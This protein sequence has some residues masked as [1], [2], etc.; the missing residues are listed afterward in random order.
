MP[1]PAVSLPVLPA[2]RPLRL[3]P[4]DV[5]QFVRMEQC[6]RYLRFRLA[7]RAGQDFM[8]EYGVVPQRLTPLLALSG[9]AFEDGVEADLGG[10]FRTV[11]YAARHGLDHNRP[12]NNAEIVREVRTLAP[13]QSVLLL[14]ALLEAELAGWRLRGDVDL[15]RLERSSAGDLSVL[16][17]DMKA[18]AEVKVE[19]RLQVAFYRLMLERMLAA[20]GVALAPVQTGILFRPPVDPAPEDG[21]DDRLLLLD[22]ALGELEAEDPRK[23]DLVKLRFFA[24]LTAEPAAAV[25]GVSTSTAEKDW[26]YARSWLR[27]AIDRISA[28]RS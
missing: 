18:T 22:E 15:L 19:H 16:V 14:Q 13:G 23:A 9:R 7:E 10:R 17:T 6:Q 1:A 21:D 2:D 8:R 4:T 11:N 26:A 5:T 28:R 3:T 24:G 27:V 12:D 20:E 25:L